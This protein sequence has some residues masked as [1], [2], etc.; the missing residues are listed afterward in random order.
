MR[1]TG[2]MF[3]VG[4]TMLIFAIYTGK[5]QITPQYYPLFLRSIKT[6]FTF[7][8]VPSFGGVLASFARG[9]VR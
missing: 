3:N 1:I 6:A 9:K 7:F 2:Q 5:V 4:I 8:S